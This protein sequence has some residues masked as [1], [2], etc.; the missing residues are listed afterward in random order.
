MSACLSVCTYATLLST[1]SGRNIALPPT[2]N[3]GPNLAD[4]GQGPA[5]FVDAG[6]MCPKAWAQLAR[7]PLVFARTRAM[8]T[9]PWPTFTG[10]GLLWGETGLDLVPRRSFSN[11]AQRRNTDIAKSPSKAWRTRNMASED[12]Q[13]SCAKRKLKLPNPHASAGCMPPNFRTDD[14]ATR[15]GRISLTN[16]LGGGGGAREP[17]PNLVC[18]GWVCGASCMSPKTSSYPPDP[19]PLKTA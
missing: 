1:H 18:S 10:F 6:R 15:L 17:K 16:P 14:F 9:Q 11:I 4:V 12:L 3:P 19:H 5:K 7:L 8:S 13:R 2:A